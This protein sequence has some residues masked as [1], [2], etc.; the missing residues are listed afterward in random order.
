[1]IPLAQEGLTAA[2][3]F[4]VA[5]LAV[6]PG[7]AVAFYFFWREAAYLDIVEK[8]HES[9]ADRKERLRSLTLPHKLGWTVR[10]VQEPWVRT[11]SLGRRH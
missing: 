6:G 5:T 4:A 8:P 11:L 10:Q 3:L 2:A 1:M 9:L 7:A